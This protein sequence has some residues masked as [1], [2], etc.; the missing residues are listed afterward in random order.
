VHL[1][2]AFAGNVEAAAMPVTSLARLTSILLTFYVL[3]FILAYGLFLVF[4]KYFSINF[5]NVLFIIA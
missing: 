3:F 5:L 1:F 4:S 2:P